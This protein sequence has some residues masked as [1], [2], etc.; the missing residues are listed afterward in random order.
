M[1][2]ACDENVL[3]GGDVVAELRG[4]VTARELLPVGALPVNENVPQGDEVFYKVRLSS[5]E[6]SPERA[7][8]GTKEIV[9]AH[10][11]F[12]LCRDDATAA[13]WSRDK[14]MPRPRDAAPM[15]CRNQA[16][17]CRES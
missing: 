8:L 15:R 14:A 6:E 16:M 17:D 7:L 13:M 3:R 11:T 2:I 1:A 9:G 4:R 12:K 10:A 5:W